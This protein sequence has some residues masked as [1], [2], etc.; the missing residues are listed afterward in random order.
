M[1]Y[2][3]QYTTSVLQPKKYDVKFDQ[4]LTKTV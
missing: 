4:D 3:Y 1:M 2:E